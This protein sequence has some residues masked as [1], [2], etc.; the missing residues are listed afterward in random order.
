[1]KKKL[2]L[3]NVLLAAL[4]VWGGVV[5]YGQYESARQRYAVFDGADGMADLP[6]MPAAAE[7]P[8]V[9]AADYAAIS[10]RLLL[11]RDRNPVIEVIVP[12]EEEVE[13]PRLPLLRGVIDF[14]DGPLALL[15][16]DTETPPRW[17]GVG[18]K[19]GEYTLE[20]FAEDTLTLGWNSESIELP[21]SDLAAV[22]FDGREEERQRPPR[23]RTASSS[24]ADREMADSRNNKPKAS[25]ASSNG[26]VEKGKYT[27]GRQVS[28]RGY[29]ADP[30]DGAP[31]GF[32]YK[33]YI[34]RVQATPFGSQHW[35]E[36]KE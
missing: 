9:R 1:M 30:T 23:R 18:E 28:E 12:D 27:I 26:A 8:A 36:K 32:E 24:V 22:K 16:P 13:Q 5:F 33:G 6:A 10:Q 3:L 14:G 2:G 15:A 21:R 19:V 35:W 25:L 20:E 31:D 4:F 29:A 7:A 17:T 11:S 34:R